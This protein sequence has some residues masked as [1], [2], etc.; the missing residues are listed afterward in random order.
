MGITY[1]T[2]ALLNMMLEQFINSL[3]NSRLSLLVGLHSLHANE[4]VLL[5]ECECYL[6]TTTNTTNFMLISK[7]LGRCDDDLV[8]RN[9]TNTSKT[10]FKRFRDPNPCPIQSSHPSSLSLVQMRRISSHGSYL[11]TFFH[12]ISLLMNHVAFTLT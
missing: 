2:R 9:Y 1:L 6:W 11:L 5:G 3:P 4:R 10:S 7:A 8:P 12:L